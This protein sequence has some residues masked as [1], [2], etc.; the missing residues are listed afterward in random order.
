MIAVA[1]A[2]A[3][4]FKEQRCRS[5]HGAGPSF[6]DRRKQLGHRVR[7]HIAGDPPAVCVGEHDAKKMIRDQMDQALADLFRDQI[8][9]PPDWSE[10]SRSSC[11]LMRRALASSS[12]AVKAAL[13]L[14]ER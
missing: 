2:I 10:T 14:D 11:S 12:D 4:P 6:P 3:S 7:G 8:G 5:S 13:H 1:V 9:R